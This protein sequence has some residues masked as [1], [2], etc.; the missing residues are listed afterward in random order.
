[1]TRRKSAEERLQE[2]Q[3]RIRE[4]AGALFDDD[5]LRRE[6]QLDQLSADMKES[7][8]SIVDAATERAREL[9]RPRQT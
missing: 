9:L 7:V 8:N 1:M 6:G 4:A 5:D 3:G 2:F